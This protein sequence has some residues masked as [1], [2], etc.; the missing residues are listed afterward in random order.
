LIPH[1]Q[2]HV[3]HVDNSK[4]PVSPAE[5]FIPYDELL[6][7]DLVGFDT[8]PPTAKNAHVADEVASDGGR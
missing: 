1:L 8:V 3:L 6:D 5:I 2:E 7:R 4:R